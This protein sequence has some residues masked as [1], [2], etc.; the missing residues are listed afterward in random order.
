MVLVETQC[1]ASLPLL[2][3]KC[4]SPFGYFYLRIAFS[5]QVLLEIDHA[6]VFTVDQE[7]LPEPFGRLVFY[8]FSQVTQVA[9]AAE[10]IDA[11]N[12]GP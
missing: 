4:L 10:H 5:G 2:Q 1:I 9:V 7:N 8:E 12:P 3:F 6:F 11:L